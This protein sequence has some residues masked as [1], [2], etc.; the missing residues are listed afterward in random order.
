MPR[1]FEINNYKS[2]KEIIKKKKFSKTRILITGDGRVAKG[3]LELLKF[4]N[5]NQVSKENFLNN[6]FDKPIFCNLKTADYVKSNL[7][8]N[9]ENHD[10]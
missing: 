4:T 2:L 1:A 10:K 6:K 3:A 9:F 8:E 5:I 7:I